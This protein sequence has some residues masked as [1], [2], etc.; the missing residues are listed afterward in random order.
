MSVWELVARDKHV[1]PAAAIETFSSFEAVLRVNDAGAWA[2]DGVPL[3]SEVAEIL[4][5]ADDSRG[6]QGVLLRRDGVTLFAGR[7]LTTTAR[8][9]RDGRILDVTGMD[10]TG[11]LGGAYISPEPASDPPYATDSYDSATF[12]TE[13][14]FHFYLGRNML[15]P[16]TLSHRR[17]VLPE[18]R[19]LTD[20]GRG[21]V[22]TKH[23]RL[24]NILD[25]FREIAAVDGMLF[26]VTWDD[27][28]D[29][30]TFGARM[31]VDLRGTVVFSAA[32]GSLGEATRVEQA[33]A[34]TTVLGLGQGV[35]AER[36]MAMRTDA[37]AE[38]RYGRFEAIKDA[39]S[40]TNEDQVTLA[41][42]EELESARG[43]VAASFV[44]LP[45]AGDEYGRT[46]RLGDRVT[47]IAAGLELDGYVSEVT[48]RLDERGATIAP[49]ITTVAASNAGPRQTFAVR[50]NR[51]LNTLEANVEMPTASAVFGSHDLRFWWGD[52]GDIPAGWQ[53]ADGTG[54]TPDL[55]GYVVYGAGVQS[56]LGVNYA[57]LSTI[58][59]NTRTATIDISHDHGATSTV[60]VGGPTGIDGAA[61]GVTEV[62]STPNE[63]TVADDVHEHVVGVSVDV[64]A[65]S[66]PTNRTNDIDVRQAGKAV[67]ILARPA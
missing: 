28:N 22:Q 31:P 11:R 14:L 55:R 66:A 18:L 12:P 3:D 64:T 51:R 42:N 47:V 50:T 45:S 6:G 24:Q 15:G 16:G 26:E 30:P 46:Y 4:E 67:W 32:L 34:V 23:G 13:S 17:Y 56:A 8:E 65:L 48:F 43:G 54:G 57:L 52:P 49:T 21:T 63:T 1:R 25:F 35:G 10:E 40:A 62:P 60:T 59:A 33:P 20:S 9:T 29:W 58:G 38:L 39:R 36:V 44:L 61:G 5:Y 37:S 2:L 41:L 19:A 53:V 27:E 7:V